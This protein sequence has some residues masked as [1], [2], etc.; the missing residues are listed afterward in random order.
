MGNILVF[1]VM[2]CFSCSTSF[3]DTEKWDAKK[4]K[5]YKEWQHKIE[6]REE[7]EHKLITTHANQ[8]SLQVIA[9]YEACLNPSYKEKEKGGRCHAPLWMEE[10]WAQDNCNHLRDRGYKPLPKTCDNFPGPQ[11]ALK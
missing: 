3:A 8:Y 4:E 2:F 1:L 9:Q 10:K 5:R 6:E 7:F 11:D